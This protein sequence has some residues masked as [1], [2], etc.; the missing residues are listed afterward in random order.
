[1]ARKLIRQDVPADAFNLARERTAGLIENMGFFYNQSKYIRP[2][3]ALGDALANAYLQGVNDTAAVLAKNP[4][5]IA[6]SSRTP[7]EKT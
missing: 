3:D 5:V 6:E 7:Q 1:M 4:G 2:G